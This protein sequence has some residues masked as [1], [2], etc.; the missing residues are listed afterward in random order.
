MDIDHEKLVTVFLAKYAG[1]AALVKSILEEAH[2][3]YYT[4][5]VEELDIEVYVGIASGGMNPFMATVEFQVMPEDFE[6][7]KV[8]LKDVSEE[9]PDEENN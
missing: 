5:G 6:Q 7:A 2:I 9:P 3:Q 4:K 1:V 8:L